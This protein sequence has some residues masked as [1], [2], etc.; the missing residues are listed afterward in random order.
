MKEKANK[1]WR[2]LFGAMPFIVIGSLLY[3][4]IFIKPAFVGI[5]ATTQVLTARDVFYDVAV[6][7][8]G[9]VWAVGQGGKIV[10]SNDDGRTWVRQPAAT[11]ANLQSITAWDAARAVVVGNDAAVLTTADSGRSWQPVA[12]LPEESAG[13]KLVRVKRAADGRAYAVGEYGVVLATMDMGHAWES[14]GK[15]EDVTWNDI[16]ANKDTLILVGEFGRIRRSTDGGSNWNDIASPLKS[17]L[18][19][20]AFSADGLLAVAVGLDGAVLLSAD[21]GRSWKAVSSGT[22]EHLFD[23]TAANAGWVA[24]GDKGLLLRA[25]ADAQTW[26]VRSLS[27]NSHAWHTAVEV[28]PSRMY[29][30]GATLSAVGKDNKWEQFK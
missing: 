11:D 10:R 1:A 18:L 6:P 5:S 15:K 3:A 2:V 30:A 20:V 26:E 16:A 19:G 29:L 23:V 14:L 21:D 17:S 9:V 28:S 8:D 4:G 13:R 12:G 7:T 24:V 22:R 27:T 25:P